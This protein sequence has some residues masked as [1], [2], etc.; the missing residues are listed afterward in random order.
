MRAILITS[1]LDVVLEKVDTTISMVTSLAAFYLQIPVGH[2]EAGL[3][4]KNRHSPFPEELNRQII[5]SVT[6]YYFAPT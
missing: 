4:S 3:R 1:K 6:P 5:G 2:V